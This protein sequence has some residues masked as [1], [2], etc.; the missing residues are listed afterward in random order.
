MPRKIVS[1][2]HQ[3]NISFHRRKS[4]PTSRVEGKTTADTVTI[5]LPILVGASKFKEL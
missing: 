5:K 2:R 4:S 3:Q 1:H